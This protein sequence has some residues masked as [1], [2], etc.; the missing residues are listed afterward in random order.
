MKKAESKKSKNKKQKKEILYTLAMPEDF[1]EALMPLIDKAAGEIEG[2]AEERSKIMQ[3]MADILYAGIKAG[4]LDDMRPFFLRLVPLGK[5]ELTSKDHAAY[6]E[7]VRL[8]METVADA[9]PASF[10]VPFIKKNIISSLKKEN[11]DLLTEVKSLGKKEMYSPDSIPEMKAL[12]VLIQEF[13]GGALADEG[14][15]VTASKKERSE[16]ISK[17]TRLHALSLALYTIAQIN[18]LMSKGDFS[19]DQAICAKYLML[20]VFLGEA[21]NPLH[22]FHR[23]L[24]DKFF[25]MGASDG[26][27]KERWEELNKLKKEARKIADSRWSKKEET[28]MH[29]KMAADIYKTLK[30]DFIKLVEREAVRLDGINSKRPDKKKLQMT[31]EELADEFLTRTI[32]QAIIP[33][34]RKWESADGRL[35][36]KDGRPE[37]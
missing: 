13:M 29:H 12:V 10:L 4:Q 7:A 28:M 14:S 11:E 17:I 9:V 3:F 20:G 31:P 21:M 2:T 6:L 32:R 24:Q 27:T 30:P 18:E 5:Y 35:L 33:V 16:R 37:K 19:K 26:V 8:V 34:G 25:K 1:P 36:V 23:Q 15:E 22:I